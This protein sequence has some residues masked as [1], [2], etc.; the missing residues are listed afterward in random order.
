MSHWS[1]RIL[2][3]LL[4]IVLLSACGTANKGDDDNDDNTSP[5]TD[6]DDDDNDDDNDNDDNDD[7]DDDNDDDTS[8]D[9][10]GTKNPIVLMHGFFGWGDLG[11]FSYFY[12]VVDDLTAKGYTVIEPAV[13]P[14]NS[15]EERSGEWVEKINAA[16][17]PDQKINISTLG[18]GD[19]VGALVT[20]ATPHQGTGLADVAMGLIPGF[21]QDIIDWIM[22]MFGLDWDGI[23]ELSHD[24]VQN[25]FNPANPDDPRVTYISYQTDAEDNCFFLLEPTHSLLKLIDGANDG[26]VPTASAVYGID[27]GI[28]SADHWSI[29]GQPLGLGNFDQLAFY[30]NIAQQLRDHGF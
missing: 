23:V 20:V 25:E 9:Y 19:R 14:V 12:E 30:G 18:W 27:L 4:S 13:S 7:N 5:V 8:P 15:M 16:F 2:L 28:E 6:D 11:A 1:F 24:Y 29:I 21:G 10:P 22:N 26:I 17:G 3:V